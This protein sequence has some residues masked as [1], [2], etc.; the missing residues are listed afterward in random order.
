MAKKNWMHQKIYLGK[1]PANNLWLKIFEPSR[2]TS[3]RKKIR[4]KL[5]EKFADYSTEL[6]QAS[7]WCMRPKLPWCK[8]PNRGASDRSCLIRFCKVSGPAL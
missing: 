4:Q 1:N 3:L 7:Y 5:A 8:R 2:D 6:Y